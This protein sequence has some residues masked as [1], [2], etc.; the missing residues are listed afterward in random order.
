MSVTYGFYNSKNGDRK[1]D[2]IQI[3]SIFDGIILD[4]VLQNVGTAMM[5][6][7]LEG[8]TVVVGVGR[9]WFNHTW[10][11]NDAPLLLSIPLSEAILNRIDAVV[12]EVDARESVR[13][14]SIKVIK[15]VPA[16]SPKKPT[17]IKQ[18]DRWQY[19]LAYIRV[20]ANT[21]SIRQENITNCVGTSECPFVTAPLDKISIDSLV[22]QWGDQFHQW[23]NNVKDTL[24]EDAAGRLL[25]LIDAINA[26]INNLNTEKQNADTAITTTNI[27]SQSV[28]YAESAGAV[29][30]DNVSGKPGT[31]PPATHNHD[32][33]Y[34]PI[35]HAS[36]NP[37]YG[38]ASTSEYGHVMICNDY[39][40]GEMGKPQ[41]PLVPSQRAIF[42]LY[43]DISKQLSQ[44]SKVFVEAVTL[45]GNGSDWIL[46]PNTGNYL[47]TAQT[48]RNDTRFYIKGVSKQTADGVYTLIFSENIPSGSKITTWLTWLD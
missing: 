21:G 36:K 28:H 15:G 22:A 29:A 2:A 11:L 13:M 8:M 18:N 41:T 3:S 19:P 24:S 34:S 39:N 32:D 23:F 27:G 42:N 26:N 30:W 38:G 4:G 48:I 37:N 1:Y 33:N 43:T 25:S 20:N 46:T 17:M 31:F 12:L 47:I 16:S 6:K 9:A 10:T 7:Q 44:K 14:N 5:V 45:V 40:I 35:K